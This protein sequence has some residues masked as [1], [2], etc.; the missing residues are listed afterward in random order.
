[1]GAGATPRRSTSSLDVMQASPLR[2]FVLLTLGVNY[3]AIAEDLSASFH[4]LPPRESREIVGEWLTLPRFGPVY[5]TLTIVKFR[6]DG[7]SMVFHDCT[8]CAG[9]VPYKDLQSVLVNPC[10]WGG[11]LLVPHGPR[12]FFEPAQ[13]L[14]YSIRDD[15]QLSVSGVGISQGSAASLLS[16]VAPQ[17]SLSANWK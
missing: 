16:I 5:C 14:T 12:I 1:L 17:E 6:S 10:V 9:G 4:P 3:S 7:S 13:N 8:A 2:L 11:F 15:G